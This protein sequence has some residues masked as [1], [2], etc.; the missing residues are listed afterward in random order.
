M[1]IAQDRLWDAIKAAVMM[2]P[3]DVGSDYDIFPFLNVVFFENVN[4]GLKMV[5]MKIGK[6]MIGSVKDSFGAP[7]IR[8]DAV[9]LNNLRHKRVG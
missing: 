9:R 5:G 8:S 4:I 1:N 6:R 3:V 7:L 2:G